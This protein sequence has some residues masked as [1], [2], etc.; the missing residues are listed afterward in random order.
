MNAEAIF[1]EVLA[2][3][4]AAERAAYLDE[5]C[6]KDTELRNRVERLLRSHESAGSFLGKPAIQCAAE[7]LA[8]HVIGDTTDAEHSAV[9]ADDEPLGFLSPSDKPDSLGRLG[10]YEVLEVIGRGGMGIVLRAFDEKL[11]RIV[12]IK[13]MAPALAATSPP[14][15]RFLREARS[16]AAVRHEHVVD[17][18]AVEE[19]PIPYLV[20]EY[21]CGETLQQKHERVGPFEVPEVLR[22]G[23]QIARGLA[24]AH[25]RGLI[26]RDIKPSNILLEKG[27]EERVKITDFGLARAVADASLTQ[28]GVIA[29]TP[30][31]MAPEQTVGGSIDHRADLFSLGSVLYTMCSGRPPFRATSTMA[32]LKRVA[33]DTP[34]PIREIIPE[35]P[36][37]LCH[38]IAKLQAK[39][40]ED[41]FQS[42]TELAHLL[43]RCLTNLEQGKPVVLEQA[44]CPVEQPC[45]VKSHNGSAAIQPEVQHRNLPH[46]RGRWAIA[47]AVSLVLVASVSLTE[48]TG[49]TNLGATVIRIFRP[50]GTLVVET[51]DSAVKV[52]VEGDGD[53]VISGAGP[54][55]VRL[56]VGSYR[57]VAAKDGKA[58]QE[59]LVN[60]SRGGKQVVKVSVGPKASAPPTTARR[61]PLGREIRRFIGHK[62]RVGGGGVGAALSPDGRSALSGSADGTMRLWDLKTGKELRLFKH[63]AAVDTV[64][65]SPDGRRALSSCSEDGGTTRLWEVQTGKE[66]RRFAGAL[67]AFSPDGRHALTLDGWLIRLWDVD[68]G[69]ELRQLRGHIDVV[70]SAVF[71]SDGRRILSGAGWDSRARLWDV[72]SGETVA[73]FS[74]H[75][76]SFVRSVALS[77]DGFRALSG[78]LYDHLVRLWDVDGEKELRRFQGHAGWVNTVV[79]SPDGRHALSASHD[80]TVRLWEVETGNELCRFEGHTGPVNTVV[81]S[82]DGRH[83]LS[84]GDDGTVRLW[85]VPVALE[86]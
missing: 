33:E 26:H 38:I 56:K 14:R 64:G 35:V 53:I 50:E 71:S 32:T 46:G 19:Q 72:G 11:H 65:F 22:L 16:A 28:S 49:V 45:A 70:F 43:G 59:E 44:A 31:Y 7:E 36:E 8:G 3:N 86:R 47:A 85:E 23:Q 29:G 21:V 1:A 61:V 82:S 42:A 24:A 80:E 78:T 51:D 37:W 55:E 74:G 57:V 39:K 18:H 81:F 34:R 4:T 52:T 60:I 25:E 6:G 10:H 73:R 67:A 63:Q 84:G 79:F 58:I 83:V 20:M 41:R 13:V 27:A 40:P 54:Q 9:D 76:R 68:S 77:R 66:L 2:K 5:V 12:A 69:K 48:A 62:D 17:I 75:G 15:K 30:M